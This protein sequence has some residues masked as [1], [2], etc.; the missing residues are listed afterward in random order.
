MG[1]E[2]FEKKL[3]FYTN[4]YDKTLRDI[5]EL[6]AKL[7]NSDLEPRVVDVY[8]KRLNTM[9]ASLVKFKAERDYSRDNY[10]EDTNNRLNL[11]DDYSSLVRDSI[12]DGVPVVFHGVANIGVVLE[13]IKSGGLFTPDE[14]DVDMTSFA[15]QIDVTYKDNIDVTMEF[16]EPGVNSFMP[17]GAIFV[18]RPKEEEVD[19]VINTGSSSEVMG[20]VN[21]VN[22]VLEPE[23]LIS[24]ITTDENIE[25]L[26]GACEYAKIDASKVVT[27][28][29]FLK[30]CDEI[31]NNLSK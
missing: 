31:N 24:I 28:D 4:R 23:R 1:S 15:S 20:G 19:N 16:A 14:R 3:E 30:L 25:L 6:K 11:L 29:C 7:M 22:F 9:L 21:G 27:H 13:I 26:Q 12:D 5:E 18:F 10:I 8:S 2:M 17:Y